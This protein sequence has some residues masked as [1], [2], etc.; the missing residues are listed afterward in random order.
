[1]SKQASVFTRIGGRP[2][3]ERV[4]HAFYDRA[5]AHPWLGKFF[6]NTER[7]EIERQAADFM[8]QALGGPREFRGVFPKP[9]HQHMFITDELWDLRLDVLEQTL[10]ECGVDK[11]TVAGWIKLEGA[12]H[13]VVVKQSVDECEERFPGDRILDFP[14]QS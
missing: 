6:A 7:A 3:L 13:G 8:T 10:L 9:A 2:T 14:R 5:F 1:M 12:F 4:L 11:E